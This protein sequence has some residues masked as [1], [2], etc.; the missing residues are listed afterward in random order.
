MTIQIPEQLKDCRF[1]IC[2]ENKRPKENNWPDIANYDYSAM[3]KILNTNPSLKTYGVA[4]GF[5][6]LLVIDCDLKDAQD[7]LMQIEFLRNTFIVQTAGKQLYHFYF[8]VDNIPSEVLCPT[9]KRPKGFRVDIKLA[10]KM[11]RYIDL[12]GSGRMVVAPNSE[13]ND[14]KYEVISNLPILHIDYN[15]LKNIIFNL[16]NDTHIMID[17]D[18]KQYKNTDEFPDFDDICVAIK[19]NIRIKDIL[20][21]Q[22]RDKNPTLCPLGHSSI[23]RQSFSYTDKIWHCFHCNESGN[24]FHLYMKMHKKSFAV[25]KKELAELAELTDDFKTK[26]LVLYASSE[27]RHRASEMLAKELIKIYHIYTLRRD[28]DSTELWIY[29]NGIYTPNGKTYIKEFI[30][31]MLGDLYKIQFVNIVIEK[32]VV[33]TYINQESFFI[34]EDLELLPVLNGI[35]NLKTKQLLDFSPDY[36][37]FNKIPIYYDPRVEIDAIKQFLYDILKDKNDIDVIQELLGYLLLREYRYEKAF[38]LLGT[39]RN[40]KTKFISLIEL[41]LG[42]ANCSKVSLQMLEK[43]K[44]LVSQLYTKLANVSGDLSK[45]ALKETGVFKQLTGRDTLIADRKFTSPIEFKN[46]AKMIFACN[47]LPRTADETPGFFDRW[48][49][50]DFPFKFV[51]NPEP[52]TNEKLKDDRIIERITNNKE[53][54]GLLNWAL[55]GY[56]RLLANNRFS[57]STS[58]ENIKNKW[59]RRSSS[60][61]AF[62]QD[63]M[64][65]DDNFDNFIKYHDIMKLYNEYCTKHNVKNESIYV[66]NAILQQEGGDKKQKKFEGTQ[67]LVW[68]GLKFKNVKIVHDIGE[69]KFLDLNTL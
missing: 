64:E 52:N 3:Q 41:F 20:P 53:M 59:R 16:N 60:F 1:I 12:Q 40:G 17:E 32:I 25:A 5:N 42:E 23:N 51:E 2:D 55:V 14:R 63:E 54:S 6:N 26:F 19:Q 45:T 11:T 18:K 33:D 56:D 49:I 35:L 8:I 58:T 29:E 62:F 39:G 50:L 15:F 22:N 69:E 44:F 46:Y 48:N 38:M 67:E 65:R 10:D 57:V 43:E 9:R 31:S 28:N 27:H 21:K 13:M 68:F 34:N 24:I 37:F 66:I 47:E 30:R 36:K 4:T 61:N 7:K